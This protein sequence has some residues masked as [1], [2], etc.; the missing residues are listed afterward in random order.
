MPRYKLT[1]EYDGTP[2]CGWQRQDNEPSVQQDIEEAFS[3]FLGRPTVIFGSGRTDS[4]VHA[5]GQVAHVDIEKAYSTDAVQGAINQR[6]RDVPISILHV[7][8]VNDD[9]HARFS[10][11][12]RTYRYVILNRRAKPT[13][14]QN[15]VWWVAR[16]LNVEAMMEAAQ[17][18]VGNH[19]F[20]SF[21]DSM[22]Q[23]RSPI[24]TLDYFHVV[25][26]GDEIYFDVSSRSFLH[27]QVRNMVGTL[28][29]VGDGSWEP[30]IISNILDAK[31]RRVAGPTAPACG[32]YL[33]SIDF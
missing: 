23:S 16:P 18:F 32:L 27:R 14:D 1:I 5:S 12:K 7:E 29:R 33:T 19:D 11:I 3:D 22:C 25:R 24:K 9:F 30:S 13:F 31:D 4:G 8:K 26:E 2:Y 15:S 20:T 17:H 28:K 21:R 10:A 6:L